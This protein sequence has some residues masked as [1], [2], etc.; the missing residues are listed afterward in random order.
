MD[1]AWDASA[2]AGAAVKA[3]KGETEATVEEWKAAMAGGGRGLHS[4]TSQLTVS[5]SCRT[6][7]V[8]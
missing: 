4:S 7:W 5:T 6:R 2:E 1:A 8:P 3:A